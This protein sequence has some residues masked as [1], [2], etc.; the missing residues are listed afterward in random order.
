MPQ[1][2]Y[3]DP[4]F[5]AGY[6]HLRDTA[7]GL[8]EVLEQPALHALLPALK[9][10]RV[11]ELGCGMG[12]FARWCIAQGAAYVTGIDVSTKMLEVAQQENAHP[13]IEYIHDPIE[14]LRQPHA[15]FDVVVSSLALHYV[16]DYPGVVQ[17]V[18]DWLKPEG[19]FVFS[20][21]H[22]LCTASQNFQG[23]IKDAE[24]RKL[25]WAV[26]N[27]GEEGKREQNWFVDSVVKYHRTFT[28]YLNALV[29]AGLQIEQVA[30]P[31]ATPEALAV[32]PNLAEERRRPPFL[33]IRARRA[34]D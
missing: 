18:Q 5:F 19:S 3:D 8:N 28:T 34:A 4:D 30:E 23:W 1:N 27:Y 32:R 22:P 25:Y 13:Q 33:L 14:E 7:S 24:G 10:L 26:D 29:N 20:V 9:G 15:H 6:K 31:E 2:I 16:E 17:R 11:L 21:E 12:Q